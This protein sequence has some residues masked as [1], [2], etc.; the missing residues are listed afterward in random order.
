[1]NEGRWFHVSIDD[2]SVTLSC[3]SEAALPNHSYSQTV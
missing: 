3:S 1:M 2:V